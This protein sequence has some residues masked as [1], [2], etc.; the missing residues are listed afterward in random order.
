MAPRM[1]HIRNLP[2]ELLLEIFSRLPIKSLIAARGVHQNWRRL[3]LLANLHPARRKLLELYLSGIE[4]AIFI[5]SRPF[6]LP[7]IRYFDR[8]AYIDK[9]RKRSR[10]SRLPDEFV[11]W[12]LEYPTR[13]TIMWI[14]PGLNG[15]W[16]SE[17]SPDSWRKYGGNCLSR[18]PPRVE[19]VYLQ[20]DEDAGISMAGLEVWEHGCGWSDWLITG[21]ESQS[22]VGQVYQ[23]DGRSYDLIDEKPYDKHGWVDYLRSHI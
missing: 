14:W 15:T 16:F 13:A 11:F 5:R 8:V 9:L 19:K 10:D 17:T 20:T 6:I 12:I 7:H 18:M 1:L 23:L 3:V 21:G 22:L 4:S 2:N